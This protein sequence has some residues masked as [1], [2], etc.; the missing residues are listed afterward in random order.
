MHRD[1]E[2]DYDYDANKDNK[3][4][5][6]RDKNHPIRDEPISETGKEIKKAM[7]R[8]EAKIRSAVGK[9]EE[10]EEKEE[11]TGTEP[12]IGDSTRSEE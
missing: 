2:E 6:M 3:T 8:Y 9:E 10:E 11:E 1:K 7:D 4:A 12:P 5:A